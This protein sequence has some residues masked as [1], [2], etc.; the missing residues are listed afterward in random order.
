MLRLWPKT[1]SILLNIKPNTPVYQA[2]IASKNI[3]LITSGQPSLNPRL[4]KEAD[5]LADAG[6]QVT[7]IYQY[8]N[9]WGTA[10]DKELIQ[11][12]KWKAIR[13]GGDPENEP[14]AYWQSKILQKM[15]KMAQKFFGFGNYF[16]E[17]ILNRAVFKL[18]KAASEV[19]APLYIAHNL[20]A[21][22]AAIWAAQQNKSKCGFD[23]EDFHRFEV[24][25]HQ[26]DFDVRL[27]T[28]LEDKYIP[29]LTYLS[30]ASPLISAAYQN[31]YQSQHPTTILN[32]FPKQSLAPNKTNPSNSLKLFW[33]SQ[34]VGINRGLEAVIK[35]MGS[36]KDLDIEL[37]LLGNYDEAIQNRFAEI[38]N[39]SGLKT[40]RLFYNRPLPADE[41]F[42]FANQFDV[43]LATE[44]SS[45][46][47]RDICLTNK[48][49]TYVQSGLAIIASNTSAQQQL[50]SKYPDMG[51]I[52]EQANNETLISALKL[53]YTDRTLLASHQKKATNYANASLNWEQEKH[54][55]LAI[56]EAQLTKTN[57]SF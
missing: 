12:K 57:N 21:L 23:A 39:E 35:A 7:V 15:A 52:Y 24:S 50:L 51:F 42:E 25:D 43:G 10:L 28:Y 48:I 47:N 17:I 36:L 14:L 53:Y 6:Y 38:A 30:T 9:N 18:Y 5:A 16:A 27:K 46:K 11:Q 26:L 40:N 54:I 2:L 13:V 34:T 41:I 45:P 55:F 22:P 20:G 37:H 44:M 4:V 29:K 31:L 19:Q 3:V 8:W 33:F 56:I 1:T 32:T 49:F